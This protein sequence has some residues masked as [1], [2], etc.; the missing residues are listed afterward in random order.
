MDVAVLETRY[1]LAHWVGKA[2]RP[3]EA[4]E[5]YE[6]LARRWEAAGETDSANGIACREKGVYWRGQGHNDG[7]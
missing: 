6:D 7:S 5:I 1:N 3:A 4:A 2:G